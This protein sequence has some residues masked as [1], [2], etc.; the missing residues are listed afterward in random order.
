MPGTNRHTP[1]R[2]SPKRQSPKRQSPKRQSP[3]QPI[4]QSANRPIS[5][6]LDGIDAQLVDR[7]RKQ[8]VRVA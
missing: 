2:Q 5:I 6:L 8:I 1:K 4:G 7:L 3:L